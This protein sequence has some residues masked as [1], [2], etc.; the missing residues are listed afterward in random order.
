MKGMLGFASIRHPKVKSRSPTV[1]W[2]TNNYIELTVDGEIV[3]RN[4]V[5]PPPDTPIIDERF[6]EGTINKALNFSDAPI[7][8]PRSQSLIDYPKETRTEK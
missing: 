1:N 6:K 2:E 3:D 5:L 7:L 8:A 4:R